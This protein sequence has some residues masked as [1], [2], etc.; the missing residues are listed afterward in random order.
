MIM[1]S[2]KSPFQNRSDDW[3]SVCYERVG[4]R[5]FVFNIKNTTQ[6][7][8]NTRYTVYTPNTSLNYSGNSYFPILLADD[9]DHQPLSSTYHAHIMIEW[10]GGTTYSFDLFTGNT[11]IP[12]N[13]EISFVLVTLQY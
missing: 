13:T 7:T 3:K 8:R 11:N 2:P 10:V 6:L 12:V 5:I 4:F 1:I 9:T